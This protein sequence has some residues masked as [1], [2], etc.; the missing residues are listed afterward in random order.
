MRTWSDSD[1]ALSH[2]GTHT[3]VGQRQNAQAPT[4]SPAKTALVSRSEQIAPALESRRRSFQQAVD[5]VWM[6][7]IH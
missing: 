2:R 7:G 5:G 4:R 1:A 3:A 6:A